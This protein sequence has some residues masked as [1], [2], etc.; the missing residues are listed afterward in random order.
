MDRFTRLFMMVKSLKL[1]AAHY[2][3][4]S[5]GKS[6]YAS[7]GQYLT[8]DCPLSSAA[9]GAVFSETTVDRCRCRCSPAGCTPLAKLLEGISWWNELP[10]TSEQD[11]PRT[12]ERLINALFS[13]HWGRTNDFHWIYAAIIRYHTFVRLGLRHVCCSIVRNPSG[14]LPEEELHE[15]EE[16]DSFL[17]G[18][19]ES[20]LIEFEGGYCHEVSLAEFFEWM[21]MKWDPRMVEVREELAAQKL[22]DKQLRDA[23]LVGVVWEAYGPQPI[24]ESSERCDV[25]EHDLWDA[26]DQLDLI[27]TDPERPTKENLQTYD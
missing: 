3:M 13:A 12:T 4:A 14:P 25:R 2:F 11:F 24:G 20:L 7:E 23:E 21:R 15:I 19:F 22:T 18:L 6:G 10:C 27:A 1:T 17:L 5:L 16:E 26:M 9:I 8:L